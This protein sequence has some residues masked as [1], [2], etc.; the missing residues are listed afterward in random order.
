MRQF[1]R[2][3]ICLSVVVT[4]LLTACR[5]EPKLPSEPLKNE[6]VVRLSGDP[7]NLNFLL[8]SDASATEIFR[9]I[10][11]PM[12][13]FNPDDY[14]LTP[15]MIKEMPQMQEITEGE[16]KGSIAFDFEILE[17]ATWDNG[18]PITGEDFLFTL[19]AVANPNYASPHRSFT[20]YINKVIIDENNPKKF[21]VYGRKNLLAKAVICNFEPMPK[22]VYDPDGLLNDFTLEA[23]KDKANAENLA[24]DEK[25]KAFADKFQSPLHL[26]QPAGVSYAG[27]YKLESWTTG[28]EVVL[29]KKKNWW[30]EKIAGDNPLL[31]N[32]PDKITYKIVKD[33]NA[34]VS[35]AKNGEIDVI[36][37]IPWATFNPLKEDASIQENFNYFTPQKILY[38][39]IGLNNNSP[40]LEDKRVRQALDYL[41]NRDQVFETVYFGVKNPTIGPIHPTKSYYNKDL[42]VRSFNV[43][44]AKS[45][46]AE[47]GWADTDGNGVVDKVID[48]EK[49]E[50]D[51]DFIYGSSYQDYVSLVAIFKADAIKAGINIIPST[52][53]SQA[54][55]KR[56]KAR[57]FDAIINSRPWYPLPKNLGSS[58]HTRGPSN[59][60]SFSNPEADS[61]MSVLQRT[62]DDSKL[63][64][65]YLRLQ[66]IFHEEVP[67]IFINTGIDRIIVNKKF[68][69]VRVTAVSPHYYLNEFTVNAGVPVTSSNN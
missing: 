47:A 62:I 33:I 51:I 45:L 3:F 56:L 2:L 30:G 40:R 31:A 15:V 1:L 14:Q 13:Q 10:S 42:T 67:N 19:K 6:V 52:I 21:K 9:Y 65:I 43:E 61:L 5:N 11:A 41:F 57:D 66:E 22:Y 68:D 20:S 49:V 16:F 35:L 46:L 12:A 53:E 38:R 54:Y 27:P 32:N 24:K 28:Q 18:T 25:L 48:G 7:E 37:K 60:G 58:F 59:Y 50:M 69:N 8:A 39:Y 17:E 36:S 63:P 26:S 4:F 44:K 23:L 55:F 34:A 29:T 64:P